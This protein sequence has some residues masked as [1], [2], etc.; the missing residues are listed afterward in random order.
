MTERG[1]PTRIEQTLTYAF[2]EALPEDDLRHEIIGGVHYVTPSPFIRHQRVARELLLAIG[3]YLHA[4]PRGEVF[5]DK[6]DVL[7]GEH[8]IV[9]PDLVYVSHDSDH[10]LT[11]KNM[12]GAPDLVIEIASASTRVRDLRPKRALYERSGVLE[13][14]F[15][16]PRDRFVDV[17]RASG[18]RFSAPERFT[19]GGTP[20]VTA[21]L[22]G[23]SIDLD[24]TFL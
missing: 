5:T 12:Q 19:A 6:V 2:L 14:W 16:E 13:Y 24:A 8:D 18:G 3:N 7:L 23:L 20:L 10:V 9:V 15:V 4:H 22:P 11:E 21:L 17:C 1:V